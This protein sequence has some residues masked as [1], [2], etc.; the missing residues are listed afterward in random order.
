MH[1]RATDTLTQT[2]DILFLLS[3]TVP[4]NVTQRQLRAPN[5]PPSANPC[6]MHADTGNDENRMHATGNDEIRMHAL[7]L[8]YSTQ[9]SA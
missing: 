2:Q 4:S 7:T 5:A 6:T 1:S 8:A 3:S 9:V